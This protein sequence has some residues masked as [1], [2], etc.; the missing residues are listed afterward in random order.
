MKKL[1]LLLL[2]IPVLVLG[3]TNTYNILDNTSS[4]ISGGTINGTVIG[5]TTPA[6]GSFTA[7]KSTSILNGGTSLTTGGPVATTPVLQVNGLTNSASSI[8][9]MNWSSTNGRVSAVQF[10][11]SDSN[12]IGTHGI[13]GSAEALGYLSW[14]GDDGTSFIEAARIQVDVN[15]TPSAG[16]MP[17]TIT[18]QTTPSG[19]GT[20]VTRLTIGQSGAI[21]MPSLASSS[22]AQTGTVCWTTGGNLTVDTTVACLASTIKVKQNI[23]PLN[24]GMK[25]IMAMRPISYDLKPEFNPEHLGRQVGLIAEEV[26]LVDDRLIAKDEKGDPRGVRYMQ[27][28]AVLVKGMQEQQTMIKNLQRELKKLRVQVTLLKK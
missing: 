24:I 11:R 16:V 6:A 12:V 13:V 26:A 23:V 9:L 5:G 18:I 20:P 8:G 17:G 28:T 19:S 14:G 2:L 7:V 27:M 25:E 3:Q 15:G 10:L 22:A 21:T 1:L 4:T